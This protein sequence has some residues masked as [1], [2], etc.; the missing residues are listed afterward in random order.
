MIL[1]LAVHHAQAASTLVQT[2]STTVAQTT[3]TTVAAPAGGA[4]TAKQVSASGLVFQLV[5]GLAVVLGI[6]W[7]AARVM[8]GRVGMSNPK[9]RNATLAVVGRQPLGKGVQIAIVKAGSEMYLLGVT[10]HQV[11][12]LARFQP[13]EI[14]NVGP[15]SPDDLPP[16]VGSAPGSPLPV[17]FRLQSSIKALQDRTLRRG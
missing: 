5:I 3:A 16:A 10:A 4:T 17:P 15:G 9:K 2:T 13:D 8:K 7:V 1:T 6:I 11:T 12:R 14:D